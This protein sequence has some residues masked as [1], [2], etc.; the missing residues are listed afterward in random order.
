MWSAPCTS[1]KIQRKIEWVIQRDIHIV[2]EGLRTSANAC[3]APCPWW[4]KLPCRYLL[5]SSPCSLSALSPRSANSSWPLTTERLRPLG[6][7]YE[8]VILNSVFDFQFH[9]NPGAVM[10]CCVSAAIG[11]GKADCAGLCLWDPPETLWWLFLFFISDPQSKLF[12]IHL[13]IYAMNSFTPDTFPEDGSMRCPFNR[14][15]CSLSSFGHNTN[16]TD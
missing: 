5:L 9:Q 7:L 3:L 8:S 10:N 12:K 14:R 15:P 16:C 6:P 2:M 4:A 11:L 1:D 13:L